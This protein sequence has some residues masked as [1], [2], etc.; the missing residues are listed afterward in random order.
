[1]LKKHQLANDQKQNWILEYIPT[2]ETK[3]KVPKM[4]DQELKQTEA[5]M[6]ENEEIIQS[7][8][9]RKK[10]NQNKDT[11]KKRKPRKKDS[12]RAKSKSNNN[13]YDDGYDVDN[14]TESDKEKKE[15]VKDKMKSRIIQRQKIM[16]SN[17]NVKVYDKLDMDKKFGLL[18]ETLTSSIKE[19][20]AS[21]AVMRTEI[22]TLKTDMKIMEQKAQIDR[23]RIKEKLDILT[24]SIQN[25][26]VNTDNDNDYYQHNLSADRK[27][28]KEWITN[29]VGFGGYYS[30][31]I[32]N[33]FDSLQIVQRIN[34]Q[35]QLVDIDIILKGH[36]LQIMAEM[37]QLQ[38]KSNQCHYI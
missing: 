25:R 14:E 21:I 11:L 1:M 15:K 17:R 13:V 37:L 12:L 19:I 5:Q 20:A 6:K 30:N 33:G 28:V 26:S 8:L 38:Q 22:I 36:Q 9:N 3:R 35:Q 23:G 27:Q 34:D 29:T 10:I 2:E 16:N 24:K 7:I 31:F 4:E 32:E 18:T